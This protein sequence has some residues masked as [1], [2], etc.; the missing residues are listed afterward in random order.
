MTTVLGP[1]GGRSACVIDT[2]FGLVEDPTGE[3]A[4]THR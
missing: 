3:E 4:E 2:S 1:G